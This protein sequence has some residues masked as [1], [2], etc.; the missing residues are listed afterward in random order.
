MARKKSSRDISYGAKGGP[1]SRAKG[2]EPWIQEEGSLGKGFLTKMSFADQ[3]KAVKRAFASEK[4]QHRDDYVAAYR[5]T[6]GKIMV[7]NRSTELRRKYG[8]K[9]TKIRDWF[10]AEYG[11]GSKRWPEESRRA[12][13]VGRLKNR[14]TAL[15]SHLR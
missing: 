3:K 12:A 15:P 5:S 10:V 4:K 2:Y 8:S 9:I 13:N 14:L 11:E 6:L 1:H 7:L